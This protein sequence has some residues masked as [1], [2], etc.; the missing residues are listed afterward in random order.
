[1]K[2]ERVESCSHDARADADKNKTPEVEGRTKDLKGA[3]VVVTSYLNGVPQ[4]DIVLQEGFR[5]HRFGSGWCKPR[6]ILITMQ[7][8][9]MVQH[10]QGMTHHWT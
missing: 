4:T 5:S 6:S 9:A 10:C 8:Q 3:K 1:M 2:G 7:S